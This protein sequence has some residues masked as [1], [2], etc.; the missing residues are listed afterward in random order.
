MPPTYRIQEREAEW[1]NRKRHRKGLPPVAPLY[2][3]REAMAAMRHFRELPYGERAELLPGV[4]LR[5]RDAGHILGSA[6]VELWL[7]KGELRRKFVCSGDLGHRGA[8][9]LRDREIVTESDLVLMESTYGDRSHRPWPD[10]WAELAQVL[11]EAA[12]GSGNILIPA[13][14]VDRTQELLYMMGR[15]AEEWGLAQ[16]S[17]FLDSPLAIEATD[18]YARHVELYDKEATRVQAS[19]GNPFNLPNLYYSRTARDSMAII[20]YAR[21]PWSLPAVACARADASS[22]T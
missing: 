19:V 20:G 4:A 10:T 1:R 12:G 14:A 18:I 7:E 22:T 13:F 21:G 8:L 2:G 11:A 17:L 9:I 5:L 3:M 16:W 6:I 15:H